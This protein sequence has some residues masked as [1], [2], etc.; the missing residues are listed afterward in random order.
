MYCSALEKVPETG[1]WRFMDIS[2]RFE[3]T[4]VETAHQELLNEFKG[5]TLPYNHPLTR[6]IRHVVTRILESSNLGSLES[7]PAHALTRPVHTDDPW[8]TPTKHNANEMEW[9]LFVVN[10]DNMINAMASYGNIVVF[11]GILPVAKDQNGLAAVLGHE[12]AHV[13]ARHNSERYSSMKVFIFLASIMDL[14]GIPL[15]RFIATVLYELP[16]SRTQEVEA[17]KIGLKLSS[18]ACFDPSAVPEMFKRLA[19]VEQAQGGLSVPFLNTHPSSTKRVELLQELL[20]QAYEERAASNCDVITDQFA[21]F[22]DAF[23]H[24]RVDHERV[25]DDGAASWRWT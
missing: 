23:H 16:N 9:H 17:D 24:E 6:H 12:I 2:P 21:R 3:A 1:R 4:L 10:D 18:R 25:D 20:P 22:R 11:T 13:V 19:Q 7:P 5:K 15:S 14:I 8:V